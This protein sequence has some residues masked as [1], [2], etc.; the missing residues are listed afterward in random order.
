M[1]KCQNIIEKISDIYPNL[2]VPPI[3]VESNHEIIPSNEYFAFKDKNKLFN[4]T[5]Y[6]EKINDYIYPGG[7]IH[8][9]FI[10]GHTVN[11]VLN[12]GIPFYGIIAYSRVLGYKIL[13]DFKSD[14]YTFDLT[15]QKIKNYWCPGLNVI[16]DKTVIE[17]FI[18]NNLREDY[19]IINLRRI[20]EEGQE[21]IF[22]SN[23][24]QK[25][26]WKASD[27]LLIAFDEINT[28][29]FLN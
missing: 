12:M 4:Q 15:N 28:E 21:F 5:L 29:I 25:Y 18:E 14:N 10:A 2:Y 26:G 8:R 20:S 22:L 9:L 27:S 6:K 1:K 17:T 24:G 7:I 13:I 16:G 19:G 11:D 23:R 3:H